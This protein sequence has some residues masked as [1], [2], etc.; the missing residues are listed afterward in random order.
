M[1]NVIVN[2]FFLHKKKKKTFFWAKRRFLLFFSNLNLT[3]YILNSSLFVYFRAKKGHLKQKK[4]QTFYFWKRNKSSTCL[5]C[6][7]ICKTVCPSNC[8]NLTWLRESPITKKCFSFLSYI[9][10]NLQTVYFYVYVVGWGH[11]C[12]FLPCF[13]SNTRKK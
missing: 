8:L 5:K 2:L 12:I 4:T 10:H 6:P 1:S 11:F 7:S 13:F 9:L 3:L